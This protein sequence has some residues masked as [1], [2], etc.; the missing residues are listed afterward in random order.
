MDRKSR[1]KGAPRL[2]R[3]WRCTYLLLGAGAAVCSPSL[4]MAAASRPT[5]YTFDLRSTIGLPDA[6]RWDIYHASVCLQGLVNRQ[7][8]R[9][10]LLD[11]SSEDTW[12]NRLT[13]V[14]GL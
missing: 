3:H 13:E 12:R 1:H 7:A 2:R 4:L 6:T 11:S 5:I 10:F 8:P 9:V 14:G